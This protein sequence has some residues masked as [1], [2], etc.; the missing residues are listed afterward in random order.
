MHVMTSARGLLQF[1]LSLLF[2]TASCLALYAAWLEPSSLRL[3]TYSVSQ[4]SAQLKGLRIAVISDLHGGAPFID[5]AQ[6]DRVVTMTN[7]AKPDLVLLTGDYM[8]TGPSGRA[9][10][11]HMPIESMVARL[12]GLHASLGVYAVLGNH[13]NW[14]DPGHI[15]KVFRQAGIPVL[16]NSRVMLPSPRQAVALVGIGDRYSRQSHPRDALA[17]VKGAALCF[18][19]SPDIFPTLP[20]ACALTIA[21]HTH[22]GQVWLPFLGRPAVAYVSRYGQK[23]AIGAIHEQGK[24]LFV[25][26]GIGTSGIPLRFGVPPE[27]SLLTLQ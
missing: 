20:R 26:P 5:A 27:I 6:I 18:S 24:A 9:G 23:Y 25:S 21:G 19:H 14:D 22:G 2:L 1:L 7:A 16:E 17:D 10:G 15:A 13:D 4:P 11:H 3:S 12:K 8:T